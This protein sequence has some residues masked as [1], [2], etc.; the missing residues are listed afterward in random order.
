MEIII[1][2]NFAEHIRRLEEAAPKQVEFATMVALNR[3]AYE[4]AQA[5]KQAMRQVFDK[6]TPWVI[7]GVRYRK[8]TRSKLV[9]KV[10]LDF[11]GNKQGVTVDQVLAAQIGGG[12]RRLKRFERALSSAGILP[13]GM[14]VV[15]GAAAKMDSYGNMK[16]GQIVQILSWFQSFGQQG[17]LANMGSK[18]KAR[19][20][21]DNKRTGQRGFAYFALQQA[22]GRLPPGIYQRFRTGFGY[23]VKPVM[24]FVPT[25]KY[26][27]RLN[28][29]GVGLAAAYAVFHRELPAALADAVRTA[30]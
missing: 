16:A 18:G 13:S 15:P 17:Y 2:N 4:G 8:A 23:S 12:S 14:S 9:S 25:P 26:R 1:R 30:R 28:F 29:Y 3:A 24:I 6:P 11:W 7:G 5:V 22:H 27:R 20:G 10:D 19:L 21:R